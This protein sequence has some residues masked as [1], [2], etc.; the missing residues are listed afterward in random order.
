MAIIN[1]ASLATSFKISDPLVTY[2]AATIR[3]ANAFVWQSPA[4]HT[5]GFVG[6]GFTYDILGAPNAGTVSLFAL[7]LDHSG[8]T[9]LSITGLGLAASALAPLVSGGLTAE[10]Q[11]DLVWR[12]VLAGND[13]ISL[14]SGPNA[15]D[16]EFA[17]D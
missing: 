16:V 10:Q 17:G 8:N 14:F 11:N 15:H 4:G 3:N 5:V 13:T 9:D 12:L 7:D 2:T 1:L 6:V